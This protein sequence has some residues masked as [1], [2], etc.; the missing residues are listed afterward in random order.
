MGRTAIDQARVYEWMN[1]LSGTLHGQ[2]FGAVFR[3][4]RFS[5]QAEAH[6]GVRATGV[7]SVGE[8]FSFIE[9]R[10]TGPYAVGNGFTAVDPFLLVFYRWGSGIGFDMSQSYPRYTRLVQDL[11]KRESVASALGAEG[12][13]GHALKQELPPPLSNAAAVR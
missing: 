10:L 4:Q 8:G 5:D 7:Q 11:V 2:G 1:W 9:G 3:P 12:L 13:E 6:P